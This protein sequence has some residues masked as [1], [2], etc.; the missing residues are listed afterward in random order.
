MTLL[1]STA[2][3]VAKFQ[4]VSTKPNTQNTLNMFLKTAGALC[5]SA[6]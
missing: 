3:L 6:L 1:E 4:L 2:I 5:R